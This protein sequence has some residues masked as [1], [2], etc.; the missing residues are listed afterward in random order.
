MKP[1]RPALRAC[2]WVTAEREL[3]PQTLATQTLAAH[4]N[5]VN[6]DVFGR[7]ADRKTQKELIDSLGIKTAPGVWW[8]MVLTRLNCALN[9]AIRCC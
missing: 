9:L 8:P 2:D 7:L 3:W 1:Q 5:F 6:K 4:G